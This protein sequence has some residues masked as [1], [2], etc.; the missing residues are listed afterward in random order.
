MLL[1]LESRS[2]QMGSIFVIV[3]LSG[4]ISCSQCD[5]KVII[6]QHLWE[7]QRKGGL[8]VEAIVTEMG[9][10]ISKE[11]GRLGSRN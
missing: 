5:H 7:Y 11:S 1:C 6:M 2:W 3:Q 9:L 4:I 8:C 10:V